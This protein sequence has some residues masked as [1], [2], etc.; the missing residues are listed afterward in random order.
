L[1]YIPSRRLGQLPV[2]K[3]E[4][5]LALDGGRSGLDLITR[6]LGQARNNLAPGGSLLLELDATQ[7]PAVKTSAENF[8]PGSKVSILPDLSGLDRCVEISLS[9]YIIHLC[10]SAEW[11]EA[12]ERGVFMDASLDQHGFIHCS[13]P[14]HVLQVANQVFPGSGNLLALWIDPAKI[15]S[16]IRWEP[17]AGIVYPH[18]YG[19][20]DLPAV[21]AVSEIKPDQDGRYRLLTPP[22]DI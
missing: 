6:L 15:T 12:Q 2:A 21:S 3:R 8:Y 19:P 22:D 5:R 11:L 13:Q 10:P 14:Q 18:I 7:G 4:P 1:P 17:F 9:N 20:I 16:E